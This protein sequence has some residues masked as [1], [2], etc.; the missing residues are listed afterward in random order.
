MSRIS[1]GNGI[2]YS[3]HDTQEQIEKCLK[4]PYKEC[5]NCIGH[6]VQRRTEQGK[7]HHFT[8]GEMKILKELI[9]T[10]KSYKEVCE[11]IHIGKSRYYTMKKEVLQA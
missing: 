1:L 11:V 4:C 8:H 2:I 9:L 3:T 10:G 7:Y 5:K 6:Y